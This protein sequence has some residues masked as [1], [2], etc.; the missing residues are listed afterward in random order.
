MRIA[1]LLSTLA[2]SLASQA[3]AAEQVFFVE[4]HDSKEVSS[5]F[6]V[7]FG[8]DSL[9]I[10][11]AG[12]MTLGTGHHHLIVN[13]NALTTGE[14]VPFNETHLH[15]G[16]GQTETELKLPPGD[17]TL[18]LQFANGTHQSYGPEMSRTIKVRVVDAQK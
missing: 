4:P 9:K 3:C 16:K 15:F 8:L 13:G 18:T 5:P 17:Y 7:R 14:P 2:L 11:P 1:A 6:K 10:A 12:D